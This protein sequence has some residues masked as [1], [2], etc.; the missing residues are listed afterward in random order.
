VK[1]KID[2]HAVNSKIKNTGDHYRGIMEFKRGYKPRNYFMK[3]DNGNLLP[4]SHKILNCWK[5]YFSQL[6]NGVKPVMLGR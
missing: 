5:S 6:L 1:D 4:D 2:E 3:D